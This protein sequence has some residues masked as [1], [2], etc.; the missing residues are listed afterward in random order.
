MKMMDF[1]ME[2]REAVYSRAHIYVFSTLLFLLVFITGQARIHFVKAEIES[3]LE[4][5]IIFSVL[6]INFVL[7]KNNNF[8]W[9]VNMILFTGII[10]MLDIYLDSH[11]KVLYTHGLFMIFIIYL[12]W[13]RSYQR[14]LVYLTVLTVMS[15]HLLINIEKIKMHLLKIEDFNHLIYMSLLVIISIIMAE[16]FCKK[17]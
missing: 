1:F 17:V 4:L 3:F 8:E 13:I 5:I 11:D 12:L 9:A 6:I 14:Y 10:R 15:K 16:I 7:I 2:K